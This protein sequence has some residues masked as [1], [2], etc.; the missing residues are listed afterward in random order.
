MPTT[1]DPNTLTLISQTIEVNDV[2]SIVETDPVH[3]EESGD[4]IRDLQ[5]FR[6]PAEGQT[7]AVLV[8]TVRLKGTQKSSIYFH[9]PGQEY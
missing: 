3:D 4:W 1:P 7:N 8:L 2:I 5:V 9:A 6:A